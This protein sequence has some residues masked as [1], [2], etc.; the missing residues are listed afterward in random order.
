MF[1]EE[2]RIKQGLSYISLCPLSILYNSKFILMAA[3]FGTNAVVVTRV[4]CTY[5]ALYKA[6]FLN[7]IFICLFFLYKNICCSRH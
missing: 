7:P 2:T 6:L 1:Y 5:I 4:H 3:S